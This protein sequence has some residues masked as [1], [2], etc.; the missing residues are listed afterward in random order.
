MICNFS[1]IGRPIR[2]AQGTPIRFISANATRPLRRF[3]NLRYS[4]LGSLRYVGIVVALCQLADSMAVFAAGAEKENS[5]PSTVDKSGFSLFNPT[6]SQYLRE[7]ATDGP[8][9][10]ESARTVDAGHFQVELTLLSYTHDRDSSGGM[11]RRLDSWSVAP[12]ILKVG[13]LNQLDA[14]IA[15]EPYSII[16]EQADGRD[17]T[18]RG[19]GDTTV[20]L[21][22]N[23]WGNDTEATALAVMPYVRVPTSAPGLGNDSLEGGLIL[24]MEAAL[25]AEFYLGLTT[26]FGAV[27]DEENH[28]YHSEFENSVAVGRE[29]F[30]NLF[31]YVEFFSWV[32]TEQ[33]SQWVGTFDIGLTYSLTRNVQLNAGVN[34]GLTHSADDWNP[35]V[36]LA[37]RF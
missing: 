17:I 36:G 34:I 35:F 18:R 19:F 37:W 25:P 33:F 29:L 28:G 9:A 22:Y 24:P 3:G 7:L 16:R 11:T 8:G 31:T 30:E 2:Q 32:S 6:P 23:L 12:F 15:L 5:K 26:K 1:R 14:Q 10:T 4:R 21:K 20:R 27:P 13:L